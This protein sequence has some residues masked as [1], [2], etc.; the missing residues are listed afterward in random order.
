VAISV[1]E[2]EAP[3]MYLRSMDTPH[4]E[5]Q[6]ERIAAET[7]FQAYAGFVAKFLQHLGVPLRDV[8]DLVQDVFM[9]VHR[10]GGYVAG[11]AMPRTWLAAIAVRMA[12]NSR[13][14]QRRGRHF[15]ACLAQELVPE[16]ADPAKQVELQRGL[17]SVQRAL[18]NM[19]VEQ[20]A[21]FVLYELQ[22]ETCESIAAAWNVPLGTVYSRLHS[23]R[24]TFMNAYTVAVDDDPTRRVV[25]KR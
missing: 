23:A 14:A 21:A 22:G 12:Q 18:E 20:R 25:G 17:E 3:D 11:A 6:C 7:L 16:S 8:D 5:P 15:T 4:P 1:K 10:K 19:P 24:R 13:R 9:T 2:R